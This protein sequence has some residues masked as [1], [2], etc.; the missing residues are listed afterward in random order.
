[1]LDRPLVVWLAA[2]GS[3]SWT[4]LSGADAASLIPPY[5]FGSSEG[6]ITSDCVDDALEVVSG[7]TLGNSPITPTDV[8]ALPRL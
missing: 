3:L 6:T 2:F 7:N 4:L 5:C 8:P 1:M